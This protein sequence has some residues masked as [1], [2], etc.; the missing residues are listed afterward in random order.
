MKTYYQVST[1]FSLSG[2]K[3]SL[4]SISLHSTSEYVPFLVC[5]Y[6]SPLAH[7]RFF[8]SVP[9]AQSYIDYLYARYPDSPATPPVLDSN[10]LDLFLEVT[11]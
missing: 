3:P 5:S 1:R 11:K 8:Y 4:V 6:F 7:S 9:E 10:Q 2:G